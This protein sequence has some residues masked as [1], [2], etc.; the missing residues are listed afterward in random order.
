VAEDD[1]NDR[2]LIAEAIRRDRVPTE[3]RVVTDGEE[4]IKYLRGDG[5]YSDR[6]EYPFPDLLMTD[7]KMPKM[8]GLEVLEWIRQ[9]QD[10]ANLPVVIL[11]GSGLEN[12]VADAYRKGARA[13]FVK[14]SEFDELQQVVR[15]IADH[16]AKATA[17]VLPERCL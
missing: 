15:V 11:S 2:F 5:Q 17:P 3:T 14:P 13:Y 1:P 7:L 8:N 9:H 6:K 4:A 10:C 16:W 12:D